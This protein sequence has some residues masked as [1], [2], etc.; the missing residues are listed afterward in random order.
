MKVSHKSLSALEEC[1]RAIVEKHEKIEIIKKFDENAAKEI[2]DSSLDV[3]FIKGDQKIKKNLDIWFPKVKYN[4]F[5][6]GNNYRGDTKKEICK[7]IINYLVKHGPRNWQT[8]IKSFPD[9]TW[10]FR[11]I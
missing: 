7:F 9:S 2:D 3:V 5:I 1:F 11:K 8:P 10:V 4:A 6:C